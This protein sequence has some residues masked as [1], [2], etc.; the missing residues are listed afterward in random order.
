MGLVS[1]KLVLFL[2]SE[3]KFNKRVCFF[4]ERLDKIHDIVE[5]IHESIW[6]LVEHVA[7]LKLQYDTKKNETYAKEL[8]KLGNRAPWYMT[9]EYVKM[10]R[11]LW[12]DSAVKSCFK[13]SNEFQLI[14]SAK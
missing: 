11:A 7:K 14:D 1:S 3:S 4:S 8:R 6:T 12:S 2:E 5:N 9:M 13:R 10:V